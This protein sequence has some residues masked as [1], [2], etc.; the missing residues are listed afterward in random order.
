VPEA[1]A[2]RVFRHRLA[3]RLQAQWVSENAFSWRQEAAMPEGTPPAAGQPFDLNGFF[4][5]A[6][7]VAALAGLFGGVFSNSLFR[8]CSQGRGLQPQIALE[9]LMSEPTP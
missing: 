6:A 3:Q 7:G 4:R 1:A 5:T 9:P 8:A 2:A